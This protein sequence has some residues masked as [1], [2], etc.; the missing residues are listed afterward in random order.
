MSKSTNYTIKQSVAK[1]SRANLNNLC[2][3]A[4]HSMKAH[5]NQYEEVE[6][7]DDYK[8]SQLCELYISSKS[9]RDFLAT[10][11]DS[12]TEEDLEVKEKNNLKGIVVSEEEL[13]MFR[14]MVKLIDEIVATLDGNNVSLL[15][16]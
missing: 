16:H 10:K 9:A 3:T 14:N 5:L 6:E 11:M 2:F 13:D 4:L 7:A 8:L 1:D 12:P 15:K